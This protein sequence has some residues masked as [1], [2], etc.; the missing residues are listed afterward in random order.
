MPEIQ[1]VSSHK[2]NQPGWAVQLICGAFLSRG[3]GEAA[4]LMASGRPLLFDR[5]KGVW[6]S[7]Q[8][9]VGDARSD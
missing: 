9:V 3:H 2:F 7:G 4:S 1:T 5:A 6:R 8:R